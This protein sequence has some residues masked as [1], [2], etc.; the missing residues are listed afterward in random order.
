MSSTH[1]E[2]HC[3]RCGGPNPSWSAPSPLWNEVMRHGDINRLPE[4]YDGIVCPTCFAVLAED[5]GV[6]TFWRLDAERVFRELKLVTPSGRVW[7]A[8]R[9][10]W[11]E[12]CDGAQV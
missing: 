7:N 3:H 10:M 2:D 12:P 1:P 4:P 8:E 6:A 5:M 11:E 9:W